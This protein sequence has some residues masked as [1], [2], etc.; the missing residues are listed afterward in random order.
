[1]VSCL[2]TF[3]CLFTL[4]KNATLMPKVLKAKMLRKKNV[5]NWGKPQAT[6]SINIPR[7]DTGLIPCYFNHLGHLQQK[8]LGSAK[9][10]VDVDCSQTAKNVVKLA[11]NTFNMLLT[12][13]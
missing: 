13:A 2:F 6:C 10:R 5:S 7:H 4:F 11:K 1:M 3:G 9:K 12:H 8:M